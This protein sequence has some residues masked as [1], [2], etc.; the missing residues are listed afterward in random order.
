[1]RCSIAL[2]IS[3]NFGK[4]MFCSYQIPD[5][6]FALSARQ[7]DRRQTLLHFT[8]HFSYTGDTVNIFRFRIL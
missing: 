5:H 7:Q 3:N 2:I 4:D 6:S 1:M 8:L